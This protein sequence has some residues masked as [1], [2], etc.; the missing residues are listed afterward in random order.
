MLFS[1]LFQGTKY[2]SPLDPGWVEPDLEP[3]L[4]RPLNGSSYIR[5]LC[6]NVNSSGGIY[7]SRGI[8]SSIILLC[9]T[10]M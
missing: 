9:K 5:L 6:K 1:S 10:L 3:D 2:M 8:Y 4:R 7:S